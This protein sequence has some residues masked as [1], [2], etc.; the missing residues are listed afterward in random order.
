MKIKFFKS[1]EIEIKELEDYYPKSDL[2]HIYQKHK[3]QLIEIVNCVDRIQK[4]GELSDK[5]L[6]ILEAGIRNSWEVVYYWYAG[7]YL[8]LLTHK[9]EKA[10]TLFK[11]LFEDKDC[12]IRAKIVSILQLKP[13]KKL[14][15]PILIKAINDKSKIVRIKAVEVTERLEIKKLIPVIKNQ[16]DLENDLKVKKSF[17]WHLQMLEN[18]FSIEKID[19]YGHHIMIK[20]DNGYSGYTIDSND[21]RKKGIKRIARLLYD[22]KYKI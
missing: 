16:L 2:N 22:N 8:S 3:N 17:D 6:L 19:K 4:K 14:I 11:Q 7:K 9:S 5:D 15:Q 20:R 10:K 12:D 13:E 18:G 1:V 21:V